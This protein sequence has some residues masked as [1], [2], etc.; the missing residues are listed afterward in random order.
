MHTT[1]F[2]KDY[3]IKSFLY[4]F[5]EKV[6]LVDGYFLEKK[7]PKYISISKKL[8][9][10]PPDHYL[11]TFIFLIFAGTF[12]EAKLPYYKKS[13]L[14]GFKGSLQTAPVVICDDNIFYPSEVEPYVKWLLT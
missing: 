7:F 2:L 12:S 5:G 4:I 11:S 14:F 1:F 10:T 8:L 6:P 3:E 9:K 13:L